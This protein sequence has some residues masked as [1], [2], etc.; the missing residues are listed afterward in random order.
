MNVFSNTID[1]IRVQNR[2]KKNTNG[3]YIRKISA[4]LVFARLSSIVF[5]ISNSFQF[6]R[7]RALGSSQ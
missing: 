6:L 2:M 5:Y 4:I 1:S 3:R 7:N